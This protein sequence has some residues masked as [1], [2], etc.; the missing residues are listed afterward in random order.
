MKK[1]KMMKAI[2][3]K[4][5]PSVFEREVVDIIRQTVAP[6][7]TSNELKVYLGVCRRYKADPIMKDIVPIIFNTKKGRTL[8]FI[9]TK[10]FC[11]KVAHKS[12]E[13]DGVTSS[14]LRDEKGKIIGAKA[15]CWKKGCTHPYESEVSFSEYYNDKNDLWGKYPGAMIKKVAEVVVLK[16]AFGIDMVS[17]VEMEKNGGSM[18]HVEDIEVPKIAF[19]VSDNGKVSKKAVETEV[20]ET[21]KDGVI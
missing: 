18:I 6:D 15:T 19:T 21:K 1:K 12:K 16:M 2:A 17:D 8:N 4:V 7:L 5:K 9:I 13:L 20:V 3:K 11:Y 14:V 10:N